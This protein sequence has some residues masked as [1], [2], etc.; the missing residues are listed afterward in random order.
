MINIIMFLFGGIFVGVIVVYVGE[1]KLF[2]LEWCFCDGSEFFVVDF[3]DF[4]VVIGN[5]NGGS[6]NLFRVFDF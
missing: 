2:L 6:G 5:V 3:L 1:F 4:Y